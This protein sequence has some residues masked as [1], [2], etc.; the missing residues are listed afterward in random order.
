MI[1]N[2]YNKYYIISEYIFKLFYSHKLIHTQFNYIFMIFI[3]LHYNIKCIIKFLRFNVLTEIHH[4]AVYISSII[5]V[6]LSHA[7][8]L[9]KQILTEIYSSLLLCQHSH[10]GTNCC[11]SRSPHKILKKKWRCL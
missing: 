11:T 3:F 4:K 9:Y 1:L 2:M 7:Y 8:I 5:P 10:H 6:Y